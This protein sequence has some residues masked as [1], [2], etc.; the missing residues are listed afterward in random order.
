MRPLHTFRLSWKTGLLWL[1]N[2]P[3]GCTALPPFLLQTP[4]LE[5]RFY[6]HPQ[7]RISKL[8]T[9]LICIL[10]GVVTYW[11]INLRP[12]GSAFFNYVAILFLDLIAAE[13]LV[14]LISC[15]FP[16]FV[17]SLALTA[18]ANGLWMTVG[19]F[20]VTPVVLNVFWK[21]T[22]YQF[23]YQRYAFSALVLNQMV[24]SVYTCD[25]ACNC[26]YVTSLADQCLIEGS[27]AAAQLGYVTKNTLSYV[28]S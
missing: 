13:S 25:E 26:M 17:V 1:R 24:G 18:F 28:F 21:Y 10:F 22:F 11:L 3:M 8:I 4:L 7:F 20:L 9:V 23:D 12:G 16:I 15:L 19:G 6:V 5:F 14:V 2:E 27:E